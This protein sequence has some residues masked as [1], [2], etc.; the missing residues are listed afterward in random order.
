MDW[1]MGHKK[2][3]T[4]WVIFHGQGLTASR[5]EPLRGGN[6]LFT[7]KFLE[8]PCTHLIDLG[9]MKAWVDLQATQWFWT[10][11]PGVGIQHLI[12]QTTAPTAKIPKTRFFIITS[13]M[14][15]FSSKMVLIKSIFSINFS[16]INPHTMHFSL[17]SLK[18]WQ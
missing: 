16:L 7:I 13:F 6:L 5:L 18:K 2:K 9:R 4:T 8:I 3:K 14:V 1:S 11:D 12:H 17:K 10:R 15:T